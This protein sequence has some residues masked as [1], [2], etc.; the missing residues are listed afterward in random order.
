MLIIRKADI[1]KDA[2]AIMD[3]F[4][5]IL[6]KEDSEFIEAVPRIIALDGTDVLV[7]EYKGKVVCGIGLFYGPYMCNPK[8]TVGDELFL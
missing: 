2:L 6:P 3:G 4:S 1:V 7:A 8:L 5:S